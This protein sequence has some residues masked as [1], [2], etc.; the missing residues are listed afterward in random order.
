MESIV[1]KNLSSN[2]FLKSIITLSFLVLLAKLISVVLLWFLPAQTFELQENSAKVVPYKNLNFRNMLTPARKSTQAVQKKRQEVESINNMILH[3]LYGNSD[4]GYAIVAMKS[5]PKK[6]EIISVGEKYR[7]Y[8]LKNIAL[9]YVVFEKNHKEYILKFKKV[10]SS[11]QNSMHRVVSSEP[12]EE[13]PN[14]AVSRNEIKFYES[15]PSQIWRDISIADMKKNGKIVGFKVTKIR[16]YS[17]ISALGLKKGDIIIKANGIR[18]DSYNKAFKIYK[19][20]NKLESLSLVVKRGN[21]EK[22]LIYEI[23]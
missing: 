18:L 20:I 10:K 7:G 17:K 19:D 15:H 13:Q 1:M 22:E 4:Y 16:K 11:V 8:R 5:N 21:E 6:T 3:G 12:E 23:H 14:I 2:T 9:D